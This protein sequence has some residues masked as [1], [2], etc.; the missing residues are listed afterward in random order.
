MNLGAEETAATE[1]LDVV[2][3]KSICNK[4][5]AVTPTLKKWCER[6]TVDDEKWM[7]EGGADDIQLPEKKRRRR[8]ATIQWDEEEEKEKEEEEEEE[9]EGELE[10]DPLLIMR[11]PDRTPATRGQQPRCCKRKGKEV[12]V[13]E[14]EEDEDEEAEER[15]VSKLVKQRVHHGQLQFLVKWKDHSNSFNT[16]VSFQRLTSNPANLPCLEKFLTS[17]V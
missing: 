3:T 17:R 12:V 5:K 14:E 13:E 11:A 4:A 9:E 1:E 2:M 6:L 15:K 7:E 16:W 8:R 10:E